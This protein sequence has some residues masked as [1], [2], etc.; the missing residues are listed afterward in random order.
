HR[1]KAPYGRPPCP[2]PWSHSRRALLVLCDQGKDGRSS[3]TPTCARENERFRAQ[4]LNLLC[5]QI[6]QP[7]FPRRCTPRLHLSP[8][9]R[10]LPQDEKQQPCWPGASKG[11]LSR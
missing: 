4:P 11:W 8:E 7:T 6:G 9:L 3:Y 5:W 2:G 10:I 1:A